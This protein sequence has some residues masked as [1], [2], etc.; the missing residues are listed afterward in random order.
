MLSCSCT[1]GLIWLL[2]NCTGSSLL[3]TARRWTLELRRITWSRPN[4]RSRSVTIVVHSWRRHPIWHRLPPVSLHVPITW[5]RATWSRFHPLWL[6][7][8]SPIGKRRRT[9]R[10]WPCPIYATHAIGRILPRCIA[11]AIVCRLELSVGRRP[12][13][14]A[15]RCLRS[16][17]LQPR[18]LIHHVLALTRHGL[19]SSGRRCT[20]KNVL[21]SSI[22]LAVRLLR[23]IRRVP[24]AIVSIL[25]SIVRHTQQRD[26]IPYPA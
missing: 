7:I 8:G 23:I 14:H 24:R 1:H 22:S 12:Q 20:P 3:K 21:E 6:S 15:M 16:H 25:R 2:S 9:W 13:W 19:R 11:G 17:A 26:G 4:H 10:R 5:Y 18:L